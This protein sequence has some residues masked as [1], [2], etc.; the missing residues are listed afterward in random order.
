MPGKQSSERAKRQTIGFVDFYF[1]C[2]GINQRTLSG[3]QFQN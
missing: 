3:I 1:V 2:W